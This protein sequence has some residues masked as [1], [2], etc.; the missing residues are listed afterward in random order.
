MK[1]LNIAQTAGFRYTAND[2]NC[3]DDKGNTPLYY[4]AINGDENF[5][6]YLLELGANINYKCSNGNVYFLLNYRRY[7]LTYGF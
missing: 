1:N 6:L 7:S 5:S 4:A 3:T 2:S